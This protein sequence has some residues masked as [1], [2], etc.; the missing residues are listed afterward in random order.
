MPT[1]IISA[2]LVGIVVLVVRYLIN[3]K[4]K[5]IGSCGHAC[6]SCP[7]SAACSGDKPDD[8]AKLN[9]KVDENK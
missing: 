8:E 6:G 9:D 3:N 2:V 7:H 1:F 4:K 5:G